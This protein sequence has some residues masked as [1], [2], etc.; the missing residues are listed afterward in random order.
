MCAKDIFCIQR[1]ELLSEIPNSPQRLFNNVSEIGHGKIIP[2][3]KNKALGEIG[4]IKFGGSGAGRADRW[5]GQTAKADRADK[6]DKADKAD[7]HE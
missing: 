7:G 1:Y 5:S 4:G 2:Q 3:R 6:A